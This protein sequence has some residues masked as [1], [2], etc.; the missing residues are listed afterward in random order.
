MVSDDR[1]SFL[2]E[3][4]TPLDIPSSEPGAATRLARRGSN[5]GE[6]HQDV[7]GSVREIVTRVIETAEVQLKPTIAA[8]ESELEAQLQ[9]ASRRLARPALEALR[10]DLALKVELDVAQLE[11][12]RLGRIRY[13]S[14]VVEP[15]ANIQHEFMLEA[16]EGQAIQVACPVCKGLTARLDLCSDNGAHLSRPACAMRCS[17]CAARR[18]RQHPV[19][20]CVDPT[21][22]DGFC[23]NCTGH[24]LP[25]R[26]ARLCTALGGL[27]GRM[28]RRK[29]HQLPR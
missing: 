15:I 19:G 8:R 4:F 11:L 6:A 20:A 28:R 1:R 23:S 5:T 9:E 14:T 3:V 26:R 18:C 12:A 27:R 17:V 10:R 2:H 16:Y 21:C 7:P 13:R 29:L 24:V 22:Q 25:V